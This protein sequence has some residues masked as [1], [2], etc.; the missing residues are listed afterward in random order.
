MLTERLGNIA[1]AFGMSGVSNAS[2]A[3]ALRQ[4]QNGAKLTAHLDPK[5]AILGHQAD[6]RKRGFEA[7]LPA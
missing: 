4:T 2:Q 3:R 6:L 7:H 5:P 1:G